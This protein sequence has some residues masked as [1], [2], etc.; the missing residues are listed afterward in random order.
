MQEL[1]S[2]FRLDLKPHKIYATMLEYHIAGQEAIKIFS[3]LK[4][5]P[6]PE[7]INISKRRPSTLIGK[8]APYS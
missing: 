4:P 5:L 1:L 7:N 6:V 8:R 2:L 3:L